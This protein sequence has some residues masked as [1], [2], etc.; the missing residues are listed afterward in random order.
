MKATAVKEAEN[1]QPI[2]LTMQIESA[3]ELAAFQ[4]LFGCDISVPAY[5]DDTTNITFEQRLVLSSVFGTIYNLIK[6]F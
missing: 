3:D 2:T 4:E 6:D 5:L 1:F